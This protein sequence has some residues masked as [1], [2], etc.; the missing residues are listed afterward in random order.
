MLTRVTNWTAAQ[1]TSS[2][3]GKQQVQGDHATLTGKGSLPQP[4]EPALQA[5]IASVDGRIHPLLGVYHQSVLPSAEQCLRSDRL[6]LIDWLDSLN[7]RY[8]TAGDW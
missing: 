1:E 5:V 8:E 4:A 6:R 2:E 7:V 3:Q